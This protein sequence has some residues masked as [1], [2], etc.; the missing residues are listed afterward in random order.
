MTCAEY[1]RWLSPYL[2]ALLAPEQRVQLEAHLSGCTACQRDLASLREM[3]RSLRTLDAPRAP[4]L[5]PAIHQR[6]AQE[7]WWRRLRI[8]WPAGLPLDGWALAATAV[9]A[10]VVVGLPTYLQRASQGR[11]KGAADSLS[12]A[13]PD[14][15]SARDGKKSLVFAR[16]NEAANASRAQSKDQAQYEVRDAAS[17]SAFRQIAPPQDTGPGHRTD[18]SVQES[19]G[20]PAGTIAAAYGAKV[21]TGEPGASLLANGLGRNEP[22]ESGAASTRISRDQAVKE[23]AHGPTA[24]TEDH[25]SLPGPKPTVDGLVGGFLAAT[26]Q[27]DPIAKLRAE[28]HARMAGTLSEPG[29]MLAASTVESVPRSADTKDADRRAQRA[30]AVEK[31][32]SLRHHNLT[33]EPVAQPSAVPSGDL[34]ASAR[35]PIRGF[36]D[37]TCGAGTWRTTGYV[38]SRSICEPCPQGVVCEA[39]LRDHIVLSEDPQMPMLAGSRITDHELIVLT[40]H[41]QQFTIGQRY[42]VTI[43]V[44][45]TVRFTGRY[46]DSYAGEIQLLSFEVAGD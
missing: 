21:S 41:P 3:V 16:R 18:Q 35:C 34:R 44:P 11:L 29:Q 32:A 9:L 46:M 30:A 38:V 45:R 26:G 7:P 25:P 10:V 15:S 17:E 37:G 5:L 33:S 43:R 42:H 1:R 8:H 39:C 22:M 31:S 4:D 28:Q 12:T 20:V 6:L 40:E 36:N 13:L 19:A 27:Q 23:V 2:D 14:G 24:G